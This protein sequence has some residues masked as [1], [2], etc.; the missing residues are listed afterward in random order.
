MWLTHGQTALDCAIGVSRSVSWVTGRAGGRYP[1]EVRNVLMKRSERGT[2]PPRQHNRPK[3]RSAAILFLLTAVFVADTIT[4]FEIAIAVF[5][6]VVI[7]LAVGTMSTRG[8]ILL[9]G[10]CVGLTGLSLLL[11]RGGSFEAG[12][13]NCGISIAAIATTTFLVLKTMAAQ[14]SAFEAQAQIVRVARLTSL[15]ALTASIAHEVNQPLAAIA[16]SGDACRRWLTRDPPNIDKARQA[17]DRIVDDA[18]RAGEVIMRVRSLARSEPPRKEALNLNEAIGEAIA[19]A[20]SE[21]E[22]NSIL[23]RLSLAED[24][25]AVL[26]DRV[27]ILQVIG[28]LILNAIEAMHD[29]PSFKRELAIATF[30]E[31]PSRIAF[32]VSDAGVGIKPAAHDHLFEAFW[33]TKEGG[34]GIGLSISRSIVE[35]HGGQITVTSKPRMGATFRVSLPAAERHSA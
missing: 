29:A 2:M 15:G 24:L 11:T 3:L 4:R 8:V 14:A 26:A 5:Y 10:L 30:R 25:P 27:P 19:I 22:N 12:L 34:M 31:D 17:I 33:T 1:G 16:T 20:K 32:T 18:N 13:M 9:A 21:M 6:I 28:N 23:L 35:A 7:L